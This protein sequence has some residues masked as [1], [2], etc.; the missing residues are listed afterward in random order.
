[1]E[2]DVNSKGDAMNASLEPDMCNRRQLISSIGGGCAA[3]LFSGV[4]TKTNVANAE[5]TSKLS[6]SSQ[7]KLSVEV[8]AQSTPAMSEVKTTAVK[9][10][11]KNNSDKL[12]NPGDVKNCSDFESYRE[13]KAWFDKYYDLFGD[14]AQLD[15][16]KNLIPCENLPGAPS[17][18]KTK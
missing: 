7:A 1:M 3:Y 10:T 18:K 4:V 15:K 14:V 17:M 2:R 13:A 16:N 8:K 9:N 6:L 5:E 11:T 12:E